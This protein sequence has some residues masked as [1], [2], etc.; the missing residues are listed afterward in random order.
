VFTFE[1]FDVVGIV[2]AFV[3]AQVVLVGELSSACWTR[4]GTL[5]G[6]EMYGEMDVEEGLA[7][8]DVGA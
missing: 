2:N 5:L 7:D 1:L 3:S 6:R 4:I 8:G